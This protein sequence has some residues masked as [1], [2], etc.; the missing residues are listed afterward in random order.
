MEEGDVAADALEQ[1]ALL[2]DF[3]GEDEDTE[4]VDDEP[5]TGNGGARIERAPRGLV[6]RT[7]DL[8]GDS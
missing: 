7:S 5:L 3:S 2:G 4:E 6:R 8:S 1:G